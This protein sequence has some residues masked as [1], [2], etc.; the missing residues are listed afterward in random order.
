MCLAIPGKV[1][2]ITEEDSLRMGR[3]DF[4]GTINRACL[5][6]CENV[7]VGEY[8]IVH[9]GFAIKVLDEAEAITTLKYFKE[10]AEAN[11]GA[12]KNVPGRRNNKTGNQL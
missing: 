11:A 1:L 4:A 6:Y 9:A 12:E 5:S 8:V 10:M 7:K 2:E 3:I